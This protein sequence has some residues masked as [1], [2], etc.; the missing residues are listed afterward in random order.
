MSSGKVCWGK[1]IAGAAIAAGAVA[2]IALFPEQV[3]K[4]GGFVK[5]GLA[6]TYDAIGDAGKWILAKLG[7]FADLLTEHKEISIST[8]AV[9][10]GLLAATHHNK[11]QHATLPSFAEQEDI[12]IMEANMLTMMQ[13]QGYQPAMA[14]NAKGR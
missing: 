5:D 11:P 12:K 3:D 7:Q 1:I 10:G 9:T 8:A 6:A 13:A 2:A 14:M 4:V